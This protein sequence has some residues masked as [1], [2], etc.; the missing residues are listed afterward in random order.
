MKCPKCS[1]V[2]SED[3]KECR[4]CGVI[5]EKLQGQALTPIKYN[6]ES[7]VPK[8]TK[9]IAIAAFALLWLI[10]G[11]TGVRKN[12]DVIEQM[13]EN[14]RVATHRANSTNK[15]VGELCMQSALEMG[16][17]ELSARASCYD[18]KDA[19]ETLRKGQEQYER[20]L[21]FIEAAKVDRFDIL[22][23]GERVEQ[24]ESQ[25][26]QINLVFYDGQE[27]SAS[28]NGLL[29][30]TIDPQVPIYMSFPK[31]FEIEKQGFRLLNVKGKD[32]PVVYFPLGNI[33]IDRSG[34]EGIS[35]IFLNATFDGELEST[36]AIDVDHSKIEPSYMRE[37]E[38]E[39]PSA[40]PAQVEMSDEDQGWR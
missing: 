25:E 35:R 20:D 4:S 10:L 39:Q 12:A 32:R 36:S 6:V 15:L 17:T 38:P 28:S 8:G 7:R 37:P 9:K 26:Y 22:L 24:G 27:A 11:V 23:K 19:Q 21:N 16:S 33:R 13:G 34:L 31:S 14:V 30:T 3:N 5:F 1:L 29:E 18:D 40:E 2:Q